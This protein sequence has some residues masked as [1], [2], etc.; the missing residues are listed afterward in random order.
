MV[1]YFASVFHG[2]DG[3]EIFKNLLLGYFRQGGLQHQTN[4]SDAEELRKAQREPEKH[5][6][7]VVRL[8]GV[9]AHFV[10]LPKELQ[11]EM[12]MRFS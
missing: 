6:D 10:D 8:W 1:N 11:D 12:I 4:V 9:S 2:N 7:L 3:E 5:K